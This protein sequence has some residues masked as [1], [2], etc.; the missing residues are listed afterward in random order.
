MREI[1]TEIAVIGGGLGGCAAALAALRQG[2]KVVLTEETDWL[3][4]H[5][6]SQAVPSDEHPWIEMVGNRSFLDFRSRIRDFYQRNFPLTAQAKGDPLLNP[7]LGAVSP[8]CCEPR[9]AVAALE[10]MLAPYRSRGLLQVFLNHKPTKASV[11]SDA[12]KAVDLEDRLD[13]GTVTISADLFLDATETGDLLP[14]A[15]VE[16][17]TG[18]ESQKETGEPHAPSATKPGNMQAVTWCFPVEYCDGEDHTID[19]PAQY[20]TWQKFVPNLTPSWTGRLL[21]LRDI[22]PVTLEP[23]DHHF[24]PLRE[25]KNEIWGLWRYRRI[26]Y[27]GHYQKDFSG[28]DITLVNWP[29]NDYF[30]GNI[31]DGTEEENQK[32]LE[33]ARQQSLSLLYWLQTEAPR[34]DGGTGWPGLKMRPDLVGTED[35]LAKCPYIRES[36]RIR[37]M[38]TVLEQHVGTDAR[39]VETG[40]PREEVKSASFA[41]SVGLGSYRIDLHPSTGGDNYIDISSLPFEIP[42]GALIPI[43]MKNLLAACKNIGTTHITNGCYRL[44]P[45]EWNIGEAAGLLAAWV[46]NKKQVPHQA[47]EDETILH[48]FQKHVRDQG[49]QIGW[50]RFSP[51]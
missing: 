24:D 32:H 47:R 31:F 5:M 23:R 20:D 44:H 35:G 25:G 43:R 6:T 40:A 34:D 18:A 19:R 8:I 28:N 49:I 45:V 39:M 38:F 13:G 50:P 29:M 26:R 27:A 22:H 37:A 14:L 16:H 42:L 4:G 10:E 51:R 1:H 2:M 46:K 41:D 7:G 11:E 33:G 9:A 15:G 30:L 36:R 3:G 12:V 48:D 21:S 17:V